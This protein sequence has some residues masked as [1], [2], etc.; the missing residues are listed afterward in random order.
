MTELSIRKIIANCSEELIDGKYI[1]S[2]NEI[3][4][5]SIFDFIAPESFSDVEDFYKKRLK[6]EDVSTYSTIF[7]TKEKMSGCNFDAGVAK[8]GQ[9]R[10]TQDLF[11]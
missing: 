5:K 8:P 2:E 7:I 1:Q 9:R 6:G 4:E 3:V 10:Q 11:L